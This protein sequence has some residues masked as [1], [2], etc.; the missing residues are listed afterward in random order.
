[1]QQKFELQNTTS[2]PIKISKD[3][4]S[5]AP[6]FQISQEWMLPFDNELDLIYT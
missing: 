1:M 5:K 2:T 4:C 3:G 6:N